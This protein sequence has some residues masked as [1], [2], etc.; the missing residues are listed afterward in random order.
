[1]ST[2]NNKLTIRKKLSQL[3]ELVAWFDSDDFQLEEASIKLKEA[4][5]LA[6]EIEHDLEGVE[7]EITIVKQSFSTDES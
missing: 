5:R 6:V 3:D 4:N 7:N 1:M 2:S